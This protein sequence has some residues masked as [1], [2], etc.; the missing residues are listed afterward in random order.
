[1]MNQG[2]MATMGNM[3]MNQ[4]GMGGMGMMN[5]GG[6]NNMA[7]M[8]NMGMNQGGMGAG[9][10]LA[11]VT[12]MGDFLPCI[13]A[14]SSACCCTPSILMHYCAQLLEIDSRMLL[15]CAKLQDPTLHSKM[16]RRRRWLWRESGQHESIR[17]NGL[18]SVIEDV[19][20]GC[21]TAR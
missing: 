2:G 15:P 11:S 4:G 5:Q 18:R 13:L 16:V 8:P 1:M 3:N 19:Q 20:A 17:L 7:T 14:S 12:P 9:N 21:S 6:M 10:G